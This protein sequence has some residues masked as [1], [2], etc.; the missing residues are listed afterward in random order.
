MTIFYYKD[1]YL[2]RVLNNKFRT[3]PWIKIPTIGGNHNIETPVVK[4]VMNFNTEFYRSTIEN[5]L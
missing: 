5:M 4:N 3:I 1:C 2:L